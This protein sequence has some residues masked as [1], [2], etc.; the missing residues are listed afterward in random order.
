MEG[1]GIDIDLSDPD[2]F[3][4]LPKDTDLDAWIDSA[5]LHRRHLSREW[6]ETYLADLIK[7]NSDLS[8][9]AISAKA[10][11][12]GVKIDKNKVSEKRK[13]M[14]STGETPPVEKRIGADGKARKLPTRSQPANPD[15][16]PELS[17]IKAGLLQVK[18]AVE[19]MLRAKPRDRD[20]Q[21]LVFD[22]V[23]QCLTEMEENRAHPQ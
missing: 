2:T 14:E 8:A 9:R 20:H 11:A 3:Q 10:R 1:V 16:K 23:R 6:V 22:R 18:S 7:Q 19:R 15:P 5:N 13:Q 12:G 4:K 17:I 21:R